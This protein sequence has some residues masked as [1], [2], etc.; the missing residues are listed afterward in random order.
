M[1]FDKQCIMKDN[2]EKNS[3]AKVSTHVIHSLAPP[4]PGFSSDFK[5]IREWLLSI[6]IGDTPDQPIDT[7]SFGLFESPKEYILSLVGE[8][9]YKE[10]ESSTITR[11]EFKPTTMYYKLPENEYSKLTREQVLIKVITE[12][13][14]FVE[15]EQFKTSFF[16]QANAIKFRT[17]GKLIWSKR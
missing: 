14:E 16:T 8:N 1:G 15:T 9:T 4:L 2:Q 13:Q 7:Y 10:G 5:T 6:C 11:I 3:E 17:N 12:L